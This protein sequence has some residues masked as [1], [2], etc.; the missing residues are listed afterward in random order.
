LKDDEAS[1]LVSTTNCMVQ[2]QGLPW[3]VT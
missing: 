3:K 1:T 2:V